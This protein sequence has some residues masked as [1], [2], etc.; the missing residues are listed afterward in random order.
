MLRRHSTAPLEKRISTVPFSDWIEPVPSDG[1]NDLTVLKSRIALPLL[2][3][4]ET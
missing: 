3:T 4:R 2:A 1:L